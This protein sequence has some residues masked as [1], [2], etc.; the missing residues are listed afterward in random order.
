MYSVIPPIHDVHVVIHAE[1][2][3][4]S[5][6]AISKP[7]LW[8]YIRPEWSDWVIISEHKWGRMKGGN[9]E[10]IGSFGLKACNEAHIAH[11]YHLKCPQGLIRA[12]HGNFKTLLDL[13]LNKQLWAHTISYTAGFRC[14]NQP[15]DEQPE[16]VTINPR[17]LPICPSFAFKTKDGNRDR[18]G[19]KTIRWHDA[20]FWDSVVTVNNG[21]VVVDCSLNYHCALQMTH[22]TLEFSPSTLN[23]GLV[24]TKCLDAPSYPRLLWVF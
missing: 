24:S 2:F 18:L 14:N 13:W 15:G 11:L 1:S 22:K 8:I 3:I 10:G 4:C 20:V 12:I 23:Y 5:I 19:V 9:K 6:T 7:Q 17:L 21:A 16:V